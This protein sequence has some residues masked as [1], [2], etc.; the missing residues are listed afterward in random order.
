MRPVL[1]VVFHMSGAFSLRDALKEAGRDERVVG[2]PDDLSFGPIDPPSPEARAEW[3]GEELGW[4]WGDVVA[5]AEAFWA[6]VLSPDIRPIAWFSRRSAHEYCGFLELVRCLGETACTVVDVTNVKMPGGSAPYCGFSQMHPRRIVEAGL[7]DQARILTSGEI[8]AYRETG[9]RLREEN[10]PLRALDPDLQLR[11][12]PITYFDEKLISLTAYEW[13][14]AKQA[15][16]HV[17]GDLARD[18]RDYVSDLVLI[19]RLRDLVEAKRL[20]GRGDP[21]HLHGYYVR[22]A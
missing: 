11:S 14:P 6:A 22:R 9:A 7:L 20:E 19:A 21:C 18:G 12:A 15:I 1:H 5:E 10:A 13:Q 4:E 8:M 16:G 17:M 2:L 3:C